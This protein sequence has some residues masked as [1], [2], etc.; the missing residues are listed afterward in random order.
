MT[1]A[2]LTGPHSTSR[3]RACRYKFLTLFAV[4]NGAI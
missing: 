4:V 1:V 3:R 2:A